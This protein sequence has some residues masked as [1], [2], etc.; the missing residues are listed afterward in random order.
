MK[1]KIFL[2]LIIGGAGGAA[3]LVVGLLLA[4]EIAIWLGLLAF[5][6]IAI[7]MHIILS[8]TEARMNKQFAVIERTLKSPVLYQ[9]IANFQLGR[10]VVSGKVYLCR[11]SIVFASVERTPFS[12]QEI[13]AEQLARYEQDEIHLR[14]YTKDGKEYHLVLPDAPEVVEIIRKNY[15][16]A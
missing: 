16:N 4:P 6:L 14:L 8:I 15:W 5:A 10:D 13:A 3:A 12:V 2:S 1:G 7:A 11:N 9:T